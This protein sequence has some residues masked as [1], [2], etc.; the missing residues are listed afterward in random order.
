MKVSTTSVIAVAVLTALSGTVFAKFPE[1]PIRMVVA[2]APGGGTDFT[3]R[4]INDK[5]SEYLGAPVVIDNR[6]GAG[7][8]VGSQIVAEAPADGYT[9]LQI[10]TNF[11]ILP[12]LHKKMSF[13]VI[14]DFSPVINL[15]SSPLIL[16]VNPSLPAKNVQELIKLAQSKQG[17]FNYAAPGIGSLGHLA[18]EYFKSAANV[19]MEQIAYKGGGPSVAALIANQ[20]ELYFST[21]PAAVTQVNAGRLRALGVTSLKRSGTFPQVPTIAEQGVKDFEVVGWFGMFA[22]AKTPSAIV[23]QINAA[24]NKAMAV[25]EVNDRMLASG[26]EVVGGDSASFANKVKG[27]VQK[28]SKVAANAGLTK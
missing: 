24:A 25:K 9:L 22:P 12:S 20:V 18:G 3:A 10:F 19:Q 23:T 1:R 15:V 16:V 14:K 2:S 6:G 26:V 13:D 28:W 27:D 8:L 4:A 11:A 17:K 21:L 7:G 5:F